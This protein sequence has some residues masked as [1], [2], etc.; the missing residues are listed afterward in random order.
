MV[1]IFTF[2][3]NATYHIDVERMCRV[4]TI[5][6]SPLN[7]Y[8][9]ISSLNLWDNCGHPG[10][11]GIGLYLES[12]PV[13]IVPELALDGTEVCIFIADRQLIDIRCID[14]KSFPASIE[15]S[16][17]RRRREVGGNDG[18]TVQDA[19]SSPCESTGD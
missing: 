16:P 13:S 15:S 2:I 17:S 19:A 4:D 11:R 14:T 7:V 6:M 9:L 8:R 1:D 18:E 12:G 10:Y 3:R 5:L